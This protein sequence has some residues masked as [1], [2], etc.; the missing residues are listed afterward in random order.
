M[1]DKVDVFFPVVFKKEHQFEVVS[2][3]GK[4][5][6]GGEVVHVRQA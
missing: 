6:N 2:F 4:P 3:E 1:K 5:L